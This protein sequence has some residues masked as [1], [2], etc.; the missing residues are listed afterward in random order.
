MADTLTIVFAVGLGAF[1]AAIIGGMIWGTVVWTCR[2]KENPSHLFIAMCVVYTI[3]YAALFTDAT[4][5]LRTADGVEYPLIRP[6][7]NAVITPVLAWTACVML[8][9]ASD[10]R[11]LV[12]A[13]AVISGT[14]LALVDVWAPP[15]VWYLW[16]M[17]FALQLVMVIYMARKTTRGGSRAWALLLGACIWLVGMPVVQ[18]LSWTL[19]AAVDE[20]PKRKVSEILYLCVSGAGIILYGIVCMFMWHSKPPRDFAGRSARSLPP[21]ARNSV[22]LNA[23]SDATPM[24]RTGEPIH[25]AEAT[26]LRRRSVA[27]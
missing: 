21:P 17:G 3:V 9:L 10:D 20:P 5:M 19:G 12:S 13:A 7:G 6:I 4:S 15:N 18:A 27:P 1:G 11:W 14:M 16:A 26:S 25:V 8:W 2:R 22:S 23:E 24:M